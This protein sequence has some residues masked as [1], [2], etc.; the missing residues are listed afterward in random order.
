MIHRHST[1]VEAPLRPL[2]LAPNP[3][4]HLTGMLNHPTDVSGGLAAD[5]MLP[6]LGQ[7]ALEQASRTSSGSSEESPPRFQPCPTGGTSAEA[8]LCAPERGYAR[9][10]ELGRSRCVVCIA[11]LTILHQGNAMA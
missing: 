11:W 10:G 4:R 7:Q 6:P 9:N 2:S 3:I 5:S 8:G 1:I